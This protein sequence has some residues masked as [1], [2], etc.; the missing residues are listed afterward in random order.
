MAIAAAGAVV[1]AGEPEE[2]VSLTDT[3]VQSDQ[4]A[5]ILAAGGIA[6]VSLTGSTVTGASAAIDSTTG[7]V[8]SLLTVTA[9]HSTL[10]G[11]VTTD[12]GSTTTL[13]LT[14][15]SRWNVTGDSTLTTLTNANSLIDFQASPSIGTA[16]TSAT[17]YRAVNV[18]G[19]Y[20]GAQGTV[21]VNTWL[22]AGGSLSAQFTDRLLIA[23]SAS[24]VTYVDV[25]PVSGS[26]GGL[27]APNDVI[28]AAE[29]ILLKNSFRSVA[30]MVFWPVGLVCR[31]CRCRN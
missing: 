30:A 23:G 14:D 26:P 7:T 11:V 5:A 28:D 1:R 31:S 16:P 10:N 8:P 15:A 6:N 2:A 27:T 13:A 21:A 20:S 17:S 29:G 3:T 9:D 24:G 4:G 18:T 12:A 25:K 19:N 22:N